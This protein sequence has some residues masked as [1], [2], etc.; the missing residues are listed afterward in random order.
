MTTS[1][2]SPQFMNL[3]MKVF[4]DQLRDLMQK[5]VTIKMSNNEE[6][7]FV[8]KPLCGSVDSVARPI[9]QNRLQFNGH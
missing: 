3:Y 9:I 6:I 5:G 2:P 8:L 7:T 4:I 1:E